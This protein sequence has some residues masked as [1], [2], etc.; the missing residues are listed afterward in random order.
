MKRLFP[1]LVFL[2]ISIPSAQAHH[3]WQVE[4]EQDPTTEIE[5]VIESIAWVNPHVRFKVVVDQGTTDEQVWNIAGTSVSHLARM[6]VTRNILSVGDRV[7]MAGHKSKKAEHALYLV[8]LLLPDGREAVFSSS[9]AARWTG[10]RV[11]DTKSINGQV[12][13]SNPDERPNSIFS[14]WTTTM[15][16]PESRTL[17]PRNSADFPLSALALQTIANYNPATDNPFGNCSPKGGAAIMDAPYPIQL[18]DQGDTILLKLEEYDTVRTIHLSE[19]HDDSDVEPTL[20]GYSTG[21]WQNDTLVVTTTRIDYP[22]LHVGSVPS[23][24]PQSEYMQL[25]ETFRLGEDHDRLYYTLTVTD[26]AMLT[27]PMVLSKFYQWREGESLRPY[28]CDEG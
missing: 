28:S 17:Q 19:V 25:Q 5:G 10:D 13:A 14:V 11:G 16:N 2:A 20:L 8:N 3:T 18:V 9:A 7:R 27:K 1:C 15:S 22:Y 4:Y 12:V 26:T 24:I 6:D 21:H 23:Y